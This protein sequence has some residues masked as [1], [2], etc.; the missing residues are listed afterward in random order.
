MS[1]L[2]ITTLTE[3]VLARMSEQVT[4]RTRQLLSALVRHLHDFAREVELTEAE[5][6]TAVDFLTR[7]GQNCS[8]NRQEFILLSDILGLSSL[9]IALN[10]PVAAG[11]L[12]SSVLGPFYLPDAA[13]VPPGG[14][15]AVGVAGKPT[16][17]TGCITDTAGRPLAGA[18]L[19]IWSSDG[20]GWYDVQ[21]PGPLHPAARGRVRAGAD[22]RY[23]FWSVKPA[24]YPVPTD[25]PV[26]EL[27]RAMDRDS[28]RPGHL[29]FIASAPGCAS[30]TT[31]IFASDS[32][33]LKRDAVFGV[34]ESL[35]AVFEH[36]PPGVA[37]DGRALDRPF[38][39]VNF[40]ICLR[41]G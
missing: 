24:D 40:D 22:G 4:P 5:W 28:M 32:P 10:H 26:G 36:H 35:V 2:D 1:D 11:S 9:V 30:V 12:A 37:A 7:T 15:L 21:K 34:S 8:E 41:P 38:C 25:G 14:D 18:V 19:D 33:H 17:Y 27:L 20:E 13:E 23:A 6:F 29:H 31:Q 39:T 3:A 16:F